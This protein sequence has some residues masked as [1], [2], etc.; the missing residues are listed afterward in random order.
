MALSKRSKKRANKTRKHDL[1]S[2]LLTENSPWPVQ[3]AYKALRTNLSFMLP[4]SE[5]KVV[6]VTSGFP[7]DGKSS[8]IVNIAVSFADIGNKVLLL[9]SDMRL[10]T[11]NRKVGVNG[12]PGL[13]D[14][15]TGKSTASEVLQRNVHGLDFISA[16]NIPP[17]PTWLLQSKQMEVF[18]EEMRNY[19]DWIFV[20]LPP[21]T[22]VT[23]ASILSKYMDGYLL[24][25]RHMSTEYRA[26]TDMVNQ[27]EKVNARILGFI[28]NDYQDTQS[29]YYKKYYRK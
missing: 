26:V 23:D 4:G 16:G 12:I 6:C 28:Y 14:L 29:G 27:L 18:P 9:D 8:N 17:D 22:T 20:D 10:P 5:C 21:I 19:Y 11:L 3:E 24:V 25:V 13:A 2:T 15:L 7:G 1:G